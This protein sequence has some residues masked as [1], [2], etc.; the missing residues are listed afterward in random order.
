VKLIS[1]LII[2]TLLVS[3]FIMTGCNKS[4][5]T[6]SVAATNTTASNTLAQTGV[7]PTE[8]T[9]LNVLKKEAATAKE[10]AEGIVSVITKNNVWLYPPNGG[11]KVRL[12]T[13]EEKENILKIANDFE[14]VQKAKQNV[15]VSSCVIRDY[16]WKSSVNVI[17][18]TVSNIYMEKK[19]GS[20]QLIAYMGGQCYPGIFLL[21][22]TQYDKYAY[23]TFNIFVDLEQGKVIYVEGSV[24]SI[25]IP[26]SVPEP[27]NY[28]SLSFEY[29][30]KNDLLNP[31]N[32]N[33][34]PSGRWD[35]GTCFGPP[36]NRSTSY[37]GQN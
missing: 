8:W 20:Q 3:L 1:K 27:F 11:E 14:A 36:W 35:E 13:K 33:Y 34:D 24:A 2:L 21:F 25:E 29:S 28:A 26:S 5:E 17:A 22:H 18:I 37:H 31:L 30:A 32:P 16:L 9:M 7:L 12:L 15:N 19:G 10:A 4:P 6:S 23:A